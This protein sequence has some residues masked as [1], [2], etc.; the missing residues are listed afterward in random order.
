MNNSALRFSYLLMVLSA[1]EAG[2]GA[3]SFWRE[4]FTMTCPENGTWF[5]SDNPVHSASKDFTVTYNGK[6]KGLYYCEYGEKVKYYFYV[7]GNVCSDCFELDAALFAL[8]IVA[9]M[10]ITLILMLLIYK[11]TKKKISKDTKVS[12]G[13]AQP[14]PDYDRLNTHSQDPYSFLNNSKSR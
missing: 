1:V 5:K 2:T 8:A 6:N 9:D 3:V 10:S 13:P 11:C 4:S 12:T 14:S 7:E